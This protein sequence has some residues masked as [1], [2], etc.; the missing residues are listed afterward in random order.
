ME[1]CVVVQQNL[2]VTRC[3]KLT[4]LPKGMITTPDDFRFT[5]AQAVDPTFW[6]AALLAD[7][8]VYLW[9]LFVGFEDKSEE[10]VYEKNALATIKVRNGRYEFNFFVKQDMCT[11]RAMHSHRANSGRVILWDLENQLTVTETGADEFAGMTIQMLDTLKLKISDGSVSTKSPLYL[12]LA[13]SE[14]IDAAGV[15]FDGGASGANIGSLD[16]LTDVTITLGALTTTD[17]TLSV[18]VTCD[19]TP[20][21]GLVAADFVFI[22]DSDSSAQAKT[23]VDHGDGSYTLHSGTAFVDGSVSLVSPAALTVKAYDGDTLVHVN[24]P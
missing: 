16:R 10:A 9:P 19:G 13:D 2:G 22:K 23:L 7:N 15:I 21:L 18:A 11:H 24:I 17:V 3:T 8:G 4:Q 14:E 6:Q 12:V 1:D 20:V 5:A